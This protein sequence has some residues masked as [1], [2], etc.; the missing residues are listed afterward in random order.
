[1]KILQVERENIDNVQSAPWNYKS[2]TELQLDA[3][4]KS[5]EKNGFLYGMVVAQKQEEPNN[6]QWE[7]CDGNHRLM[8]LRELGAREVPVYKLG[9]LPRKERMR[10]AVELNH[11]RFETDEARLLKCLKSIWK[12]NEDVF[13]TLPYSSSK[14]KEILS[15]FQHDNDW[16][17]FSFDDIEQL[18]EDGDKKGYQRAIILLFTDDELAFIEAAIRRYKLKKNDFYMTFEDAFVGALEDYVEL[19]RNK[20]FR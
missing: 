10:V 15:M 7:V 12:V 9:R 8:V 5:I 11:W 2:E 17:N 1:M 14:T 18:Q 13:E 4:K 19:R 20:P 6:D 16:N 3:F